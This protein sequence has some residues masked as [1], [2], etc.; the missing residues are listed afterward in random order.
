MISPKIKPKLRD[1]HGGSVHNLYAG[2]ASC[3]AVAR[4]HLPRLHPE[5][6][7]VGPEDFTGKDGNLSVFS[8]TV[9][10]EIRNFPKES[11]NLKHEVSHQ[12]TD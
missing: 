7:E 9:N 10:G 3:N 2:N 11:A 5:G 8:E 4:L 1:S 12:Q 6:T